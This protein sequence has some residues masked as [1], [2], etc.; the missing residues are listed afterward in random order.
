MIA[1]FGQRFFLF[2]GVLAVLILPSICVRAGDD[3]LA[4]PSAFQSPAKSLAETLQQSLDD[5]FIPTYAL[6]LRARE[7]FDNNPERWTDILHRLRD[8]GAQRLSLAQPQMDELI[9]LVE[10]LCRFGHIPQDDL[11]RVTGMRDQYLFC[12]ALDHA[13][14]PNPYHPRHPRSFYLSVQDRWLPILWDHGAPSTQGAYATQAQLLAGEIARTGA[15]KVWVVVEFSSDKF[16]Y[17]AAQ[18]P[19]PQWEKAVNALLR[20]T[21]QQEKVFTP[22]F[23]ERHAQE[24]RMIDFLYGFA[25]QLRQPELP[26]LFS[27]QQMLIGLTMGVVPSPVGMLEFPESMRE[28]IA[29]FFMIPQVEGIVLEDEGQDNIAVLNQYLAHYMEYHSFT[30]HHS[31]RVVDPETL[32]RIGKNLQCTFT[33]VQR[34]D[35]I[36][37]R[38]AELAQ[39]YPDP[40][41][42][43]AL[44]RGAAHSLTGNWLKEDFHRPSLGTYAETRMRNGD[45]QPL[46]AGKRA[47]KNFSEK[48]ILC[49]E[50]ASSLAEAY[51]HITQKEYVEC[52]AQI[53]ASLEKLDDETLR[54]MSRLAATKPFTASTLILQTIYER[55]LWRAPEDPPCPWQ[56][57][58]QYRRAQLIGIIGH[59]SVDMRYESFM[60]RPE[61]FGYSTGLICRLLG[62][63]LSPREQWSFL[64]LATPILG[65][66]QTQQHF[67]FDW[68]REHPRTVLNETTQS[69]VQTASIEGLPGNV[70][71]RW[72][73]ALFYTLKK[74]LAL[75]IA[76]S[77][78]PMNPG[79][80]NPAP[81]QSAA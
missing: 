2:C 24:T 54:E 1:G 17:Y 34:D 16:C 19:S 74:E 7:I 42:K 22:D 77:P 71:E 48:Q 4:P 65:M 73:T 78:R 56:D 23:F 45:F 69:I 18:P 58:P 80:T 12:L 21:A 39:A 11:L 26:R 38:L 79:G 32:A 33:L 20:D 5:I 25:E 55:G 44:L 3:A 76:G 43:I 67:L 13:L 59:L 8:H 28:L 53:E 41:T 37:D 62:E 50:L 36:L 27:R 14:D 75:S 49:Q 81:I 68:M 40:G 15:T 9:G 66:G 64:S 51:S 63:G 10:A 30:R 70:F 31:P 61:L 29:P 72:V 47:L 57:L 52:L 46:L 60:R 35:R 6:P